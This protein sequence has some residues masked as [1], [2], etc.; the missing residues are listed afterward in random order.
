VFPVSFGLGYIDRAHV[1][2]YT[3]SVYT[4][5]IGYTWINSTTIETDQVLPSGTEL[6]IRRVIPKAQLINDY[7]NAAILEEQN[8]DNSFKQAL[9][10]LEEIED[11]FMSSDDAWIIR[12]KI[13]FLGDLDM[14]GFR[15]KNLPQ[16]VDS[17]DA[18]RVQD[19][20]QIAGGVVGANYIGETAP[21]TVFN[22]MR[23]YNPAIPTT[24]TYY[25][26]GDSGQWVEETA[27]GV[28][29]KLRQDLAD[30]NSNLPIAGIPA[31]AFRTV[32][33]I[34][35]LLPIENVA[36]DV[37]GFY[38]GTTVGGG[39][40]VYKP[41]MSA[42]LHNGGTIIAAAALGSWNGE[43]NTVATFFN[44]S[45][46]GTGCYVRVTS[47]DGAGL[48]LNDQQE[49]KTHFNRGLDLAVRDY[50]SDVGSVTYTL[51]SP[52]DYRSER[53]IVGKHYSFGGTILK[54]LG[55]YPVMQPK[56]GITA[57]TRLSVS[58]LQLDCV[59]HISTFALSLNEMYIAEFDNI[60]F[61]DSYKGV[62]VINS[63]SITFRNVKWMETQRSTA[64]K[65]GDNARSIKFQDC[66]FE[67][68][69]AL[70]GVGGVVEVSGM[71][72][73]STEAQF[74]GC[75]WERSGL[76]VVSGT[77]NVISGKFADTFVRLLPRSVNCEVSGRF[78]GSS[79][80]H[81]FGY[82]NVIR[83]VTTQNMATD[84]HRWPYLQ[85]AVPIN[86]DAPTF[87]DIN[88]ELLL[89]VSIGN[90]TT[91]NLANAGIE[92]KRGSSVLASVSGKTLTRTLN[93]T[94]LSAKQCYTHLLAVNNT[95]SV[96]SVA[97][98]GGAVLMAVCGGENKLENGTFAA[99]T[100]T[101]WSTVNATLS[102]ATGV[103]TVT[104]SSSSWAVYQ[105]IDTIC[106][107]GTRYIAVAKFTGNADFCL[108]DVWDGSSG[109]R[110]LTDKGIDVYGDGDNV[111][112]LSFR[113]YRG[114][115]N[116]ISLGNIGPNATI[117][118]KYIMLIE[119]PEYVVPKAAD[120][121][122]ETTSAQTVG[123]VGSQGVYVAGSIP[124]TG[125]NVGDYCLVSY[126]NPLLGCAITAEVSAA[127]TI[128]VTFIN[129]TGASAD[130]GTG[131][132]R[133]RVF[134]Q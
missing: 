7:T 43:A 39:S 64:I 25:I 45:G 33:G 20:L 2:V 122:L 117:N 77:V 74:Q 104:P 71:G 133:L 68:S 129:N 111:A 18:A 42:S 101:G 95:S 107:Q 123:S 41:A 90:K 34:K 8:L 13:K 40:F 57:F 124:L 58:N 131:T 69:E 94:G 44:W 96:A 91:T 89:L 30:T 51:T 17:T 119:C 100:T 31:K 26:D 48:G 70:K 24:S 134:R 93:S 120:V 53:N 66:N 106:K 9:M 37:V 87:G 121:P 76:N 12:N 98:T 36:L 62:E 113:Y 75:Q 105:N 67:T 88:K 114:L 5:Q 29:G 55:D 110:P 28:D 22:G 63:D 11:G 14:N 85:T 19:V 56:A 78:Y 47:L 127:N 86:T 73:T 81:D 21:V 49:G 6:T 125:V 59:N 23:W 83:S 112:M 109:S 84:E 103:M 16:P 102:A 128:K 92:V 132:I 4:Q 97:A 52:I 15:I 116:R 61:R 54:P 46:T 80:I 38:S 99:A 35:D 108:G 50:K 32:S 60:W 1:Y 118:V 72:V 27:Q 3:G 126:S 115:S 130:L 79:V 82:N 65:I 10:W